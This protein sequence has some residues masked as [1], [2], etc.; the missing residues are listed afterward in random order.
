MTDKRDAAHKVTGAY[1]RKRAESKIE[2]IEDLFWEA[3]A[4]VSGID[5]RRANQRSYMTIVDPKPFIK[6]FESI[7][8]KYTS[9]DWWQVCHYW[10][11]ENSSGIALRTAAL[12]IADKMGFDDK[13]LRETINSNH[14]RIC[15]VEKAFDGDFATFMEVRVD[16]SEVEAKDEDFVELPRD[17]H[18]DLG[19]SWTY[20]VA[21]T[22]DMNYVRATNRDTVEYYAAHGID[23]KSIKNN[24]MKL[25]DV[26]LNVDD[27]FF[28]WL[29]K[30]FPQVPP[31]TDAERGRSERI[32]QRL[33]SGPPPGLAQVAA[34]ATGRDE[35]ERKDIAKKLDKFLKG[36][37]GELSFRFENGVFVADDEETRSILKKHI[38]R[39]FAFVNEMD[40]INEFASA[41]GWAVAMSDD[42]EWLDMEPLEIIYRKSSKT[43]TAKTLADKA[44]LKKFGIPS[45]LSGSFGDTGGL[46]DLKTVAKMIYKRGRLPYLTIK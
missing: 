12:L 24:I 26:P 33:S 6:I 35:E 5:G 8:D 15:M 36:D 39:P 40:V 7:K 37:A 16:P 38:G 9:D 43:I 2:E 27:L 45:F 25:A 21:V 44:L 42:D 34:A 19:S 20:H 31:A 32:R 4:F 30:Y 46:P 29:A 18:G 3:G 22:D 17:F 10:L 13:E 28:D 14:G 1:M 11:T 41:N 23:R